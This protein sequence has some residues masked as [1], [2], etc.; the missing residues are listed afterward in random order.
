MILT[1]M[2]IGMSFTNFI[3]KEAFDIQEA[4]ISNF[5]GPFVILF[6]TLA[7]AQLSLS[8]LQSAGVLAIIYIVFRTIGK[9]GGS[10]LGATIA[11]SPK[12]VRIGT[13]LSILPQG[14]VEIGM[15]VAVSSMFPQPEALL[16]KTVILGGILFFEI[17]RP[18]LFKVTLEHFGES[19][20]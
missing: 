7:G 2:M 6:F 18:I 20:K 13:G 19:K 16:I 14:G 3:K 1:P 12:N 10:Y 4:A 5:S 9:I 11:K 15:L 8:V 17:V